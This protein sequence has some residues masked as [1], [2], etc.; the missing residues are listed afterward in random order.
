MPSPLELAQLLAI[1]ALPVLFAITLHEVS[2]GWTAYAF[3]DDTA[4]RAGRLSL[5]PLKHVDP[6]GTVVVPALLLFLG[7]FIFGWAKP[8]PVAAHRLPH[9]RRDMAIV[10]A[11]G[12]LSNLA[13]AFGWAILLKLSL[14]QDPASGLWMGLRLMATAGVVINLVLMILNLLPVPPLDGGRVLNG[15]L[16]EPLARKM[17]RVEPFGLVIL[18]VLLAT[19][20]LGKILLPPLAVA[21]R[22]ILGLFGI[23]SGVFFR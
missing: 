1:W 9:P 20:V 15:F 5:N 14:L 22:V 6:V 11:A 16:P 17:D 2:H 8:V 12:P 3:G 10:A 13:M 4:A 7:G 23:D 18:I 19:G 21:E